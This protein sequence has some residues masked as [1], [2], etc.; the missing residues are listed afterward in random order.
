LIGILLAGQDRTLPL[1]ALATPDNAAIKVEI[2][3]IGG[4]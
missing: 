2:D 1:A 4:S 3:Q